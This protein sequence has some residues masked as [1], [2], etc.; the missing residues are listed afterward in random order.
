MFT[1]ILLAYDGSSHA[2]KATGIAADLARNCAPGAQVRV[3]VAM[4]AVSTELGEP[5]YGQLTAQRAEAGHRLLAEAAALLGEG[6]DVHTELL[7]GP[8]AESILRVADVRGC[9]LIVMGSRGLG[10]LKGLLLGSHTQKVISHSLCP[11]L[12]VR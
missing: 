10:A 11:V 7:F 4:E 3:V 2:Q 6:L 9:D 8:A 5:V 12:V 1:H